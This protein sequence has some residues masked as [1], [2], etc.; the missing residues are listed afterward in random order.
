[1]L[2]E[3]GTERPVELNGLFQHREMARVLDDYKRAVRNP[4]PEQLGFCADEAKTDDEGDG[5]EGVECRK[6]A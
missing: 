3:K 4:I 1:M 2:L 5:R 6:G